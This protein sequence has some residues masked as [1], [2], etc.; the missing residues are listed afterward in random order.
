V[1]ARLGA[2]DDYNIKNA[3]RVM[4][5]QPGGAGRATKLVPIDQP[6]D[7][8]DKSPQPERSELPAIFALP[9]FERF[10]YVMSVLERYSDQDCSLLLGCTRRD[11]VA[12]RVRALARFARFAEACG[13]PAG[14]VRRR[15]VPSLLGIGA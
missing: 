14:S 11:V 4:G 3:L 9:S 5:P 1:G 2:T 8:N 7:R 15:V 10:V 12:G 6:I 13:I